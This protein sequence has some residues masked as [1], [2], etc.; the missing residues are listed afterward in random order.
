MSVICTDRLGA[1]ARGITSGKLD[2]TIY[3]HPPTC[4][5]HCYLEQNLNIIDVWGQWHD[6]SGCT[7]DEHACSVLSG[8]FREIVVS[9]EGA[10][11]CPVSLGIIFAI[12]ADVKGN[13]GRPLGAYSQA[14]MANLQARQPWGLANGIYYTWAA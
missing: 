12:N 9:R 10:F 3:C 8:I 14:L 7:M 11:S 13:A 4:R 5:I 6:A 1:M 2:F